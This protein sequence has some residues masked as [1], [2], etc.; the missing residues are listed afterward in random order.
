MELSR[1]DLNKKI[2]ALVKEKERLVRQVREGSSSGLYDE[3]TKEKEETVQRIT[4]EK[5][6][7]ERTL[8]RDKNALEDRLI[9]EKEELQERNQKET[10][11]LKEK[12]DSLMEVR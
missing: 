1:L 4:L 11:T 9:Q 7:L 8:I 3:L 6:E 10:A 12:L 2:D 5:D